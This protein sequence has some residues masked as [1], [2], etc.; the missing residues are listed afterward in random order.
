MQKKCREMEGYVS[1]ARLCDHR[2]LLRGLILAA[3]AGL[4]IARR[5]SSKGY[6][7]RLLV[8]GI[9]SG[10]PETMLKGFKRQACWG[11]L[12]CLIYDYRSHNDL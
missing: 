9:S 11:M 6:C 12:S 7:L 10:D 4:F 1:Q 3:Y 2:Q 5:M 8:H